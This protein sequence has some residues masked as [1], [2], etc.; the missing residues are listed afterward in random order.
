MYILDVVKKSRNIDI[1]MPEEKLKKIFIDNFE[2][3]CIFADR[4]LDDMEQSRDIVHEVFSKLLHNPDDT[5]RIKNPRNYLFTVV[6]NQCIDALR[7]R[8]LHKQ[9][10]DN[11]LAEAYQN[12]TFFETE[13]IR[14]DVYSMLDKAI[15]ELPN[16]SRKIILM[17]LKGYKHKDIAQELGISIN[18][19]NTLKSLAYKSLRKSLS[20]EAFILLMILAAVAEK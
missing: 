10:M 16:R 3:V 4:Y 2:S 17:K 18:T 13:I 7:R 11:S 14:E 15:G 19:V 1:D 20:E 9:F 12:D 6:R 8:N 5:A